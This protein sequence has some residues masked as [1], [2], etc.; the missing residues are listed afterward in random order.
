M[1]AKDLVKRIL[2]RQATEWE[3]INVYNIFNTG[4][5]SRMYKEL[6]KFNSKKQQS[7]W[8]MA[9]DTNKHF[10]KKDIQMTNKQMKI[11]LTSLTIRECKLEPS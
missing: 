10:T 1:F 7:V 9:K 6:S 2:L 3:K 5:I 4:P 8:K 11:S